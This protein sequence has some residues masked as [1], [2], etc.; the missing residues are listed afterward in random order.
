MVGDETETAGALGT[1][2]STVSVTA[3]LTGPVFPAESLAVTVSE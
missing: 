3:L 2:V 1:A